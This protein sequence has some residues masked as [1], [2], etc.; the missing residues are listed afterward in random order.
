[1]GIDVVTETNRDN[2]LSRA[3]AIA[4][5]ILT[6]PNLPEA[7]RQLLLEQYR[8]AIQQANLY[9]SQLGF[10]NESKNQEYQTFE[11]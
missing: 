4:E 6:T 11:Q 3:R 10:V 8:Q 7:S 2:Q 1:M 5:R 9:H